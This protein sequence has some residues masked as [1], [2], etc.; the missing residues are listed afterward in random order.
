MD[1]LFISLADFPTLR[2]VRQPDERDERLLDER[3]Q[4]IQTMRLNSWIARNNESEV[5]NG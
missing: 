5:A 1:K 4:L 2:R 3:R